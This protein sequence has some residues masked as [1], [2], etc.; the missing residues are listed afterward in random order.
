MISLD[1]GLA[2]M[3]LIVPLTPLRKLYEN[4]GSAS[5]RMKLAAEFVEDPGK[6]QELVAESI[7]CFETY[8]NR[9]QRFHNRRS[10]TGTLTP[11]RTNC[12]KRTS[13]LLRALVHRQFDID[14][15]ELDFRFVDYEVC[16]NRTTRSVRQDGRR[17]SR[18][19]PCDLLLAQSLDKLP[20][21]GEVKNRG[22]KDPFYALIQV[23]MY[24]VE[25][26]SGP[27]LAR[28]ENFYRKNGVPLF[29]LNGDKSPLADLYLV[30]IDYRYDKP[31]DWHNKI[32]ELT[33]E[34]SKNLLASDGAVANLIRRIACLNVTLQVNNGRDFARLETLFVHSA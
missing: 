3:N 20:I 10:P 6:L 28:L 9:S 30:L 15:P 12:P 22:D 11:S 13:Q 14:R 32:Y 34:L 1:K 8:D 19:S 17:A 31:D 27:Q 18:G 26:T 25:F 23:L 24:A 16:P 5:Q 21:I 2:A 33:N 29:R 4:L 7:R